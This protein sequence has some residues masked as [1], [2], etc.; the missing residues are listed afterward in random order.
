MALPSDKEGFNG[1]AQFVDQCNLLG[2]QIKAVGGDP[3]NYSIGLI[4]SDA[5]FLFGLVGICPGPAL[6][7]LAGGSS[8]IVVFVVSMLLGIKFVDRFS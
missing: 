3:V 2:G 8:L 5:D 7:S 1:P 6:T 4:A